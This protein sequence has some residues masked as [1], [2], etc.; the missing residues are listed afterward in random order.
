MSLIEKINADFMLAYKNKDMEVK[1]FLGVLKTEVTR[2]TKTPNDAQV[3]A[4]IKSMIKNAEAT[5]SL[6]EFELEIL[7]RYL[8]K[9]M[10]DAELTEVVKGFVTENPTINMG[11]VMSHLKAN[12]D[13]LY[14]GKSAS[15]IVKSILM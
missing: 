9:Q 6:S 5:N 12:F 7:N 4:K 13:G 2:E 15:Q 8:P 3:V 11:G 10:T 1:D 14:D